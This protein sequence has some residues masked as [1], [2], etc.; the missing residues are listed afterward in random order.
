[1]RLLY[2]N[3]KARR[4]YKSEKVFSQFRYLK[5]RNDFVSAKRVASYYKKLCMLKKFFVWYYDLRGS[6][7]L[8]ALFRGVFRWASG[9]PAFLV[10]CLMRLEH[11]LPIALTRFGWTSFWNQ[12][13]SFIRSGLVYINGICC[14]HTHF[15]L[16]SGDLVEIKN[17]FALVLLWNRPLYRW[18][19]LRYMTRLRQVIATSLLV[20]KVLF[21]QRPLLSFATTF[22]FFRHD[23]FAILFNNLCA[24]PSKVGRRD[25]F[26]PS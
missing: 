14:T 12:S 4:P 9:R 11:L 26:T 24:A 8:R 6:R 16:C 19:R 22:Q 10:Y 13:I 5:L 23:C 20:P 18:S 17:W 15:Y 2:H 25:V 7:Q 21:Y 3:A 1:M